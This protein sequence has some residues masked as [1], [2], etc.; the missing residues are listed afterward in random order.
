MDKFLL[1]RYDYDLCH[2]IKQGSFCMLH[3]LVVLVPWLDLVFFDLVSV[4]S[5]SQKI[6]VLDYSV[7][8]VHVFIVKLHIC[9]LSVG[10][11]T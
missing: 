7:N 3:V 11:G 10:S 6:W 9:S 4:K 5:E 1:P 8:S 2:D